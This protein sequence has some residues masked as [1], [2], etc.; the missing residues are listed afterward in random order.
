MVFRSVD[1]SPCH[2]TIS[3]RIR[4]TDD[5]YVQPT[6]LKCLRLSNFR[7][8]GRCGTNSLQAQRDCD[9]RTSCK[10]ALTG[11]NTESKQT[12]RQPRVM[13]RT[14]TSLQR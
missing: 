10:L 7:V 1:I 4:D 12:G 5:N 8:N 14:E 9:Q 11:P 3:P 2:F 13:L 6:T